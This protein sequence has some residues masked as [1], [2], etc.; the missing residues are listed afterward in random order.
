MDFDKGGFILARH[1][2]AGS[3]VRLIAD[4]QS[5][6]Q[7]KHIPAAPAGRGKSP[8]WIG[9]VLSNECMPKLENMLPAHS[10]EVHRFSV[11]RHQLPSSFFQYIPFIFQASTENRSCR[12]WI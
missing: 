4:D 5:E 2:Y 12:I 6:K 10:F 11:L 9:R 8:Q 3:S 7:K 1:S